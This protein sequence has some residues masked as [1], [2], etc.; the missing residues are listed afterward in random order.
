MA[1]IK[2][3]AGH[4]A[5]AFVNT[6]YGVADRAVDGL[7]TFSDLIDWLRAAGLIRADVAR[8]LC[9]RTAAGAKAAVLARA[10]SFRRQL[11]ALCE[12]LS[13]GCGCT[14][15][16][17]AFIN[18]ALSKH[19]ELVRIRLKGGRIQ[20]V[21]IADVLV[22]EHI[23]PALAML[24]VSLLEEDLTLIRRCKNT[25]SCTLFFYDRTKNHRRVWCSTSAC[26]NRAKVLEYRRRQAAWKN[27]P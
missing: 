16:D 12:K 3:G 9:T 20:R 15:N 14:A 10:L 18:R 19:R 1:S 7:T 26:G 11:R 22:C 21:Y 6:K 13:A 27:K 23:V 5:L 24:S 8:N 4:P 17:I 2:T 25:T